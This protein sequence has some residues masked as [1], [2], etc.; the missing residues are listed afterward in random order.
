[1]SEEE[2]DSTPFC[3]GSRLSRVLYYQ[4]ITVLYYHLLKEGNSRWI[5]Q[6]RDQS[7]REEVKM[8]RK[9]K[10]KNNNNRINEKGTQVGVTLLNSLQ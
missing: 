3:K 8:K 1:V 4:Q 7:R 10:K 9:E 2:M 6:S 5:H